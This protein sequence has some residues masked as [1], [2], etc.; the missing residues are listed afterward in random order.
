MK[1]RIPSKSTSGTSASRLMFEAPWCMAPPAERLELRG[2]WLS[3]VIVR[4]GH[5]LA[6]P[7]RHMEVDAVKAAGPG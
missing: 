5:P 2:R 6:V 3:I 1:L 7:V 4:C